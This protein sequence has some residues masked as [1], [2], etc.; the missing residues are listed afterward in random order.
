MMGTKKNASYARQMARTYLHTVTAYR[1]VTDGGEE[2]LY[3]EQPCALSR[4]AH[5]SAPVPDER[6]AILPEAAYRYVLYTLPAVRFLLG[7]RV[8]V[9]DGVSVYHGRTSDSFCYPTHCVTV[10]EVLEVSGETCPKE[11]GV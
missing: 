1:P 8:E 9:T 7:D 11:V 2:L 6:R 10:V 3:Q 4:S 5:T